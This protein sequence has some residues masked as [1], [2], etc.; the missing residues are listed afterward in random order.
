MSSI[1]APRYLQASIRPTWLFSWPL[2]TG[3]ATYLYAFFHSDK[4]LRDGDTFWHI[5]AGKWILQHGVVPTQDPFSHTARGATWTAQEWLSE[6]IMATL[7]D[8]G[9]WTWIVAL[10]ALAFAVT[11]ALL[12]RAL[13]TTLEP[14]YAVMFAV[15][16]VAMTA[17]HLLA[18][19]HILAMPLMMIWTI[20]LVRAADAGRAPSLWLLP[21][22]T[23][24]ANLH[25]QFTLGLA[26]ACVFA[27]E[28]LLA[29]WSQRHVASAVKSWGFFLSLAV[30]S[31]LLTPHG[32]QGILYTWQMFANSSYAM[33]VIGEW[34]S[35]DFHIFQPL[36]IW[37]LGGLMLCMYQGLRL[38]PVRLLLLVGLIHLS[39]KYARSIELL[40]LLAP[41]FLASPLAAQWRNAKQGKR[42]LESVDGFFLKLAGPAGHGALLVALA[43]VLAVPLWISRVHPIDPPELAGPAQAV[44]AARKAGLDGQVLNTYD[45][46][47]Y[48]I[49]TGIPP[50]VDG[51]GEMYGDIFLKE[52]GEALGLSTPHGLEKVLEKY[53]VQWTLLMPGTPA[54][55]LLDH[56]PGWRRT[57]TDKIAVVHARSSTKDAD[58]R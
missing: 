5:A 20:G 29:A 8:T 14:I 48:L 16:A 51:R 38:P 15:F 6:V 43:M 40:G 12:T 25:G 45:W 33:D 22:M 32:T 47:G 35:P 37:L 2:L 53:Q 42:Q 28:A 23:L 50:F 19:P 34:R 27:L 55:A 36:E 9:G 4:L 7:H 39:L 41:V 17:G 46:G 1:P 31:A 44:Q 21:V 56:L 13:L 18:R 52:Y 11:I 58:T 30:A 54:V 57:Y 24:W 26:L 49:Y 10:T 3:L